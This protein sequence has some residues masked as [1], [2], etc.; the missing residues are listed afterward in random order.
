MSSGSSTA[1]RSSSRESRGCCRFFSHSD[2]TCWEFLFVC[3]FYFKGT[4]GRT[5]SIL[6]VG[7]PND[8]PDVEVMFP[9]VSS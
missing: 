4:G 3:L 9:D 6:L 5:F 1:W 2:V 7:V 8:E